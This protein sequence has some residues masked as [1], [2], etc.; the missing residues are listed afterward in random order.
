MEGT[1][2]KAKAV[3]QY[4]DNAYA[5]LFRIFQD[6]KLNGQLITPELIKSKYIGDHEVGKSLKDI[7]AYHSKKIEHTVVKGTIN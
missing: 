1:S 2:T 7:L 3:N 5:Q 6:L 4:L